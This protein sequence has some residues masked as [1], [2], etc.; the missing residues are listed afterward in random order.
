[1]KCTPA[2]FAFTKNSRGWVVFKSGQNQEAWGCLDGSSILH[3]TGSAAENLQN[4]IKAQGGQEIQIPDA[5][6]ALPTGVD[7]QVHLRFPGQESKE[8]L[9]G[10]LEAALYGGYDTVL[11][12]PNTYP[13]LDNPKVLKHAIEAAGTTAAKYPVRILF[14]ASGSIGM[15]GETPADIVGLAKA[16][17]AAITDDGWGVKDDAAME[18]IFRRS[19]DAGIPFLQHAELPGHKGVTPESKFQEKEG[20]PVYPRDAESGMVKRDVALLKKVPGARYHV[21]HISTRETL[22][23]IK[24]AK[25]SGLS[26]TCEVTPHHLYF[27]NA[28]IPPESDPLSTS[29]KMNPPLFAP[30]DREALVEALESG[31]I[32]FVS[33]DHAPHEKENKAKG[34]KLSPFG[35]RGLET[36][37][38][39]LLTLHS[40][41]LLSWDRLIEV[42]STAPRK[43]I[44]V[45]NASEPTGILFVDPTAKW[46]VDEKHLPG[47]SKNSCFL[48]TELTGRI[49]LRC[50]KTGVYKRLS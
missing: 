47:V 26:I 40:R 8:T 19:K 45:L 35:T 7:L 10:G 17:A 43:F 44:G 37:L 14:S 30:A 23:E 13:F 39:V 29:F 15:K 46:V 48:A 5:W 18:E 50:E 27:S 25:E 9:D 41:G 31:L 4:K 49:E 21:L 24:K 12:M 33:T 6:R 28:E 36:A 3:E 1:M 22:A 2:P 32:D 16:G 38:P 42:F 34:W 11:T 20:L